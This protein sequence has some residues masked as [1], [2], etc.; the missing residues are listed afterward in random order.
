MEQVSAA[1]PRRWPRALASLALV[2][3]AWLSLTGAG[4]LQG[5][6]P[7]DVANTAAIAESVSVAVTDS[8][9]AEFKI[10]MPGVAT[11]QSGVAGNY[12]TYGWYEIKGSIYNMATTAST[13]F[14][15]AGEVGG[16]HLFVISGTPS[17]DDTL[18][19]FGTKVVDTFGVA[20]VLDTSFIYMSN[21]DTAGTY[22]ET[23][24]KWAGTVDIERVDAT[25]NRSVNIGFASYF[26]NAN[27]DFTLTDFSMVALAGANDSGFNAWV[28][29][30]QTTGWTYDSVPSVFEALKYP[31]AGLIKIGDTQPT[32]N[33]LVSG[34]NLKWKQTG[35]GLF[36]EGSGSEGLIAQQKTTVNNSLEPSTFMI[37]YTQ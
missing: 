28:R 17:A 31:Q 21:A 10:P 27:Q 22:Y 2:S 18:R 19:V 3:M 5:S 6:A 32:N 9:A 34:K 29:K 23:P 36:I 13:T 11:S 37:W 25:G 15:D 12:W 33:D 26:D 20:A 14:G 24:E 7:L 35:I 1:R 8:V 30:H 16:A 4:I